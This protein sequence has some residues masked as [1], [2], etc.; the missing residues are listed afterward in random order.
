MLQNPGMT[1]DLRIQF[2]SFYFLSICQICTVEGQGSKEQP[3]VV[4]DVGLDEA[5]AVADADGDHGVHRDAVGGQVAAGTRDTF[6]NA[7][8]GFL[9][10][11]TVSQSVNTK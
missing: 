5:L 2:L 11:D 3:G 10:T 8:F 1:E 9:L 4:V 6:R 7:A